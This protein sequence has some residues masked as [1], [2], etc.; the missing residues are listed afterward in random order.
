METEGGPTGRKSKPST[1]SFWPHVHEF[2]E[3]LI[4]PTA[5]SHSLARGRL[6]GTASTP[7]VVG[8]SEV[9]SHVILQAVVHRILVRIILF[10]FVM[11]WMCDD[12]TDV[13][14]RCALIF[15]LLHFSTSEQFMVPSGIDR[16]YI[17][18]VMWLFQRSLLRVSLSTGGPTL[19][20]ASGASVAQVAIPCWAHIDSYL[21]IVCAVAHRLVGWAD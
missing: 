14:T 1:A 21:D 17:Q 11:T 10:R 19:L 8:A 2:Q 20:S 4:V 15:S 6:G 7:H 16:V 18:D 3:S 13:V 12:M 5:R 9:G